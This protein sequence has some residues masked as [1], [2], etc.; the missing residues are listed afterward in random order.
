[1]GEGSNRRVKKHKKKCQYRKQICHLEEGSFDG[2]Y[3]GNGGKFGGNRTRNR[4]F[5][6]GE[7]GYKTCDNDA[8]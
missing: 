6:K 7:K 3:F 2:Q 8:D 5:H 4:G 1:M